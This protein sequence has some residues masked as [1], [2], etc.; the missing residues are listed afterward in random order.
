[1]NAEKA[2]KQT[3]KNLLRFW[4]SPIL[5]NYFNSNQGKAFLTIEGM[6]FIFVNQYNARLL[7]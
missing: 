2:Q 1:M 4:E 6:Q 7:I 5:I 3:T